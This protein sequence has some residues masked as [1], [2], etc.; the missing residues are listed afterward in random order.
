MPDERRFILLHLK[1]GEFRKAAG[2]GNNAAW[3]CPCGRDA[4][5]IGRTG[6]PANPGQESLVACPDCGR[7]FRVIG[8]GP[9]GR[10]LVVEEL[11]EAAAGSRG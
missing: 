10:A 9:Q 2:Y 3:M 4:A 11:G 6:E 7:T 5:L 8:G 1:S